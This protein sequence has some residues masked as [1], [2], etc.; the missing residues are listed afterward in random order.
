MKTLFT[1][2]GLALLVVGCSN[3]DGGTA[4]V[5]GSAGASAGCVPGATQICVGPGACSGAQVCGAAHTWG[6][7]DCG[8]GWAGSPASGGSGGGAGSGSG[9][10]ATG[11]SGAGGPTSL[12][13]HD[14]VFHDNPTDLADWP[15]TTTIT[16]LVFQYNGQDGVHV[17]FSKQDGDGR[18]PD[19]TP[20]GWDGPLQYT[21][22]MAEYIDGQ[23]HASAAIQYWYGL[24]ASGGNVA[25]DNQVAKNW[26]YDGRWGEMAGYQPATGEMIGIFVVGGN[27]RGVTDGSQSPAKE[28]SN[29]VVVPMP[30]VNGASYTF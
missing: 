21:L 1:A 13:L 14:A 10:A 22:G 11:G 18:W 12:D 29:V 7:C 5:A 16:S 25:L 30:D 4:G 27:V 24:E 15:E 17:E 9:G 26:Y 8:G 28:R 23:W 20:P 6:T 19:V 3:E 2:I